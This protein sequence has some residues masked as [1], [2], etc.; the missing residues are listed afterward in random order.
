LRTKERLIGI[1]IGLVLTLL[2]MSC[3]TFYFSDETIWRSFQILYIEQKLGSLISLGA[4]LNLPVFFVFIKQNKYDKAY[5]II[6][7]LL[8][9]IGIIALLKFI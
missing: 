5:G 9:L 1:T 8:L 3:F 4:L 6:S 7:F 2:G